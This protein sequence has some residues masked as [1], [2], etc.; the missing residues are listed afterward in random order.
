[1]TILPVGDD[2]SFA[3]GIDRPAPDL[4]QP[5]VRSGSEGT[6][7]P[8][9]RDR[10]AYMAS[11]RARNLDVLRAKERAYDANHRAR[12]A[13]AEVARRAAAP[14]RNAEACARRYETIG[15]DLAVTRVAEV[16]APYVLDLL[17]KE[18]V[19]SPAATPELIAARRAQVFV[20]RELR[21][22]K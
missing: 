5:T 21:K 22:S 13:A 4:G 11:Y 20:N 12:R 7:S 3:G 2:F 17:R 19:P 6:A 15:R 10:A 16:S 9:R 14:G 1:M 8:V 18:G